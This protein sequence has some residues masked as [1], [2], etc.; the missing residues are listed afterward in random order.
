MVD[1]SKPLSYYVREAVA[2]C[3]RLAEDER[4]KLDSANWHGPRGGETCEVC[5]AGALMARSLAPGYTAGAASARWSLEETRLW[6]ALD[7]VREGWLRKAMSWWRPDDP[8]DERLEEDALPINWRGARSWKGAR[9]YLL[10]RAERLEEM[11]L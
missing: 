11:G 2:E 9:G 10:A 7:E 1:A 6:H 3:D 4:Y 8:V 5:L